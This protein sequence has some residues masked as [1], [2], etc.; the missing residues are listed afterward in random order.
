LGKRTRN[1]PPALKH[2]GYSGV[3]VLP[4]E[5][6]VA[7]EK[8]H[9]DLIAE[10]HPNG[11]LEEDIVMTIARLLW[12]KRHLGIYRLAEAAKKCLA[13]QS[14]PIRLLTEGRVAEAQA[15]L[16]DARQE[17]GDENLELADIA[18]A[19]TIANLDRPQSVH[20]PRNRR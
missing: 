6:K 13:Y 7:F 15:L 3:A 2:G 11:P 12:R 14:A 10:L 4:G 9:Q 1:P 20:G 19:V 5:D 8:L 17:M 16:H 18:D